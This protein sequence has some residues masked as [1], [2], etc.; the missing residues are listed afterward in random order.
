M[1]RPFANSSTSLSRVAHRTRELIVEVLDLVATNGARDQVGIRVKISL[2]EEGLEG[3]FSGHVAVQV[4]LGIA[5][6][7]LDHLEQLG[8]TPAL[9]FDFGN[10]V[11]IDTGEGKRRDAGVVFGC[12]VCGHGGWWCRYDLQAWMPFGLPFD[13][14]RDEV[15]QEANAI[16]LVHR[17]RRLHGKDGDGKS[18]FGKGAN[19][20]RNHVEH[21]ECERHNVQALVEIDDAHVQ[22]GWP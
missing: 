5:R 16:P 1:G 6:E 18:L 20:D 13:V 8:L 21:I 22:Q 3:G 4:G 11:R 2:I 19:K 12:C 17:M 7:P 9:L 10:V 15:A 14:H